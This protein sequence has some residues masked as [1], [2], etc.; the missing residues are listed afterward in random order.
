MRIAAMQ[1][2]DQI[3]SDPRNGPAGTSQSPAK[4]N[5]I[6]EMEMEPGSSQGL[7]RGR[8]RGNG[9]KVEDEK[10]QLDIRKK[11]VLREGD[12]TL[13][14]SEAVRSLSWETQTLALSNLI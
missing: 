12:P 10:Y 5:A 7:L 8:T 4:A 11:C 13:E 6:A 14:P 9:H 1:R 2:R 3:I